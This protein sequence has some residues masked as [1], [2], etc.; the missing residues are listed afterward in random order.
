MRIW[1]KNTAR[2]ALVAAGCMALGAGFL[3]A[4]SASAHGGGM[5]SNGMFSVLGGNQVA[6][7]IS[8]PVDVSGNSIAAIGA[9]QAAS[10]GGSKVVNRG[11][12]GGG[13]ETSGMFSIL[14]GNQLFAPISVPVDVCGNAIAIVG[15]SK[16]QCKG[17]ASVVNGGGHHHKGKHHH[18]GGTYGRSSARDAGF[19]G[20]F[21]DMGRSWNDVGRGWK[22]D[23]FMKTSGMFSILGGNQIYAPISAPINVCGNAVAVVGLAKAWCQGGAKVVNKGGR[24]GPKMKTSGMFSI[25]GGNQVFLPVS[26]PIN[27]CGN[28]VAVVGLA[29][30]FCKGGAS[31]VNGG[32]DPKEPVKHAP[33][34]PHKKPHKK[35]KPRKHRPASGHH[36]LPSTSRSTTPRPAVRPGLPVVGDLMRAAPSKA[37]PQAALQRGIAQGL[38]QG[39]RGLPIGVNAPVAR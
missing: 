19:G 10:K 22:D 27:V 16:A 35:H 38:A 3:P 8:V 15:L 14:G 6:A 17:G 25:G 2:A 23:A 29:Q 1:S 31:V 37:G 7:P 12:G 4:A 36:K 9:A 30:A 34:W 39:L 18:K 5:K 33:K 20:G 26:V 21:P 24:G 28:S 32:H 13:M 11:V